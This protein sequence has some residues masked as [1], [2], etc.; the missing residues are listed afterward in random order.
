LDE[1]IAV[2]QRT[3]QTLSDSHKRV[4]EAEATLKAAAAAA[5]DA[6]AAALVA[7]TAKP[8]QIAKVREAVEQAN[9]AL[10]DA[11]YARATAER[12]VEL[13]FERLDNVVLEHQAG[14]V[15]DAL[16]REREA[17]FTY[18]KAIEALAEARAAVTAQTNLRRFVQAWPERAKRLPEQPL[19]DV[20]TRALQ[21]ETVSFDGLL[22][23]LRREA[24]SA[25]PA[26]FL[27]GEQVR[28]K[29]RVPGEGVA[30]PGEFRSILDEEPNE[31][32]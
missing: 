31:A 12:A 16:A 3:E 30:D 13:A 28:A 10:L 2:V 11:E 29:G 18:A 21:T 20:S 17:R 19:L 25:P 27:L 15:E 32:A 23:H 9:Q 8:A 24:G 22:L 14:W 6:E 7:G 26:P 1:A 4:A 5:R